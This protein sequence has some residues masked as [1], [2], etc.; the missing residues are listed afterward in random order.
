LRSFALELSRKVGRR[1]YLSVRTLDVTPSDGT[2]VD[3]CLNLNQAAVR[4]F[5]AQRHNPAG[6]TQ[7][8]AENFMVSFFWK[9]DMSEEGTYRKADQ[10]KLKNLIWRGQ[11]DPANPAKVIEQPRTMLSIDADTSSGN[12]VIQTTIAGQTFRAGRP[13]DSPDA[14]VFVAVVKENMVV[15]IYLAESDD[16]YAQIVLERELQPSADGGDP[17]LAMLPATEELAKGSLFITKLGVTDA[18]LPMGKIMK[19]SWCQGGHWDDAPKGVDVLTNL[20]RPM[21][22]WTPYVRSLYDMGPIDGC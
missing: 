18:E 16:E 1:A 13:F 21:L 20:T 14:T 4:D 15:R 7:K 10:D 12:T 11:K 17:Y 9:P 6:W 3:T 2:L 19:V 22:M 8:K 5:A